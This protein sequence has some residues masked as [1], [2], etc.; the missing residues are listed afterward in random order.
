LDECRENVMDV[1]LA[2]AVP[3][4]GVA[5]VW[6]AY[7]KA[8]ATMRWRT[9]QLGIAVQDVSAEYRSEVIRAAGERCRP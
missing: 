6:I 7:R 1:V 4:A 5:R 9:V 2:V 8:V 3:L